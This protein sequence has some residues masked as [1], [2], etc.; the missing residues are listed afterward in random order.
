M[1]AVKSTMVLRQHVTPGLDLV[2]QK[3]KETSKDKSSEL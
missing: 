3:S 2:E 1:Q